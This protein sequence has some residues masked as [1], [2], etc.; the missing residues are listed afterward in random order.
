MDHQ[1]L[2]NGTFPCDDIVGVRTVL[3]PTQTFDFNFIM[4][5]Y[6]FVNCI[7]LLSKFVCTK[8]IYARLSIFFDQF[9]VFCVS[10]V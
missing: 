3:V 6:E 7:I 5:L 9:C 8:K 4:V 1:L 10:H 2:N